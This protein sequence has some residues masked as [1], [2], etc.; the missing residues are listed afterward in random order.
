MKLPDVNVW[1]ARQFVAHSHHQIVSEWF[2]A[3]SAAADIAFCRFTQNSVLR[4]LTTQAVA[5]QYGLSPVAN[6][7]AWASYERFTADPRITFLGEPAGLDV[8]WKRL[9]SVKT[10]SP[11]LWA[12]AYLAAFAKVTGSQLVTFDRGYLQYPGIHLNLI[13]AS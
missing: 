11:K 13:E 1:L 12:D 3:Q 10:I 7:D 9:S 8:E 6:E 2:A 4:L 5:Q